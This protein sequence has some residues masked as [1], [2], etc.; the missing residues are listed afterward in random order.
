MGHHCERSTG[1]GELSVLAISGLCRPFEN[2]TGIGTQSARD[3][4]EPSAEQPISDRPSAD[5]LRVLAGK[6]VRVRVPFL[7]CLRTCS[8]HAM[9]AK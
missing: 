5:L 2:V 6:S 9:K 3:A 7:T 1:I 4:L 8:L